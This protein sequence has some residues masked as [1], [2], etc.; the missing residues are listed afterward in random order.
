MLK[1][2]VRKNRSYRSF[3]GTH[4]VSRETLLDLVDCARLTPSSVNIQP[5]QYFLSCTPETNET[6][7]PLTAWARLLPNYDGPAKG[8]PPI[9]SSAPIKISD[10]TWTGFV[11]MWA[12]FPRPLCWRLWRRGWAAA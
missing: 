4:T 10:P 7:F 6:I 2:I 8:H 9:S 5:F 11:L 3:D 12:S 1:E